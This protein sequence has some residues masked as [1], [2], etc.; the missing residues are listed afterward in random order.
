MS[1][2]L[3]W[4]KEIGSAMCDAAIRSRELENE[5]VVVPCSSDFQIDD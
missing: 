4:S 3:L 5:Q 2:L 1:R